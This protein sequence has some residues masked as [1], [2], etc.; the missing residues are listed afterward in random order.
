MAHSIADRQLRENK[1]KTLDRK[2]NVSE[3]KAEYFS[4]DKKP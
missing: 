4:A 3:E 2:K 1:K